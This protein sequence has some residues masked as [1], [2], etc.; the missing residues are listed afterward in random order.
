MENINW[1]LVAALAFNQVA[2]VYAYVMR[3]KLVK[4]YRQS[5]HHERDNVLALMA[6]NF[7]LKSELLRLTPLR[8][9]KGRFVAKQVPSTD[10]SGL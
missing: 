6:D 9:A 10:E 8:G 4:L 2:W 1:F 7:V 3:G 5:L